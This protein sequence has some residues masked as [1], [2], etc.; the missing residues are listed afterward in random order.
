MN[1][2]FRHDGGKTLAKCNYVYDCAIEYLAP[3]YQD[4]TSFLAVV[5]ERA[6]E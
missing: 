1:V 2:V 4:Y 6:S 3:Y 5:N